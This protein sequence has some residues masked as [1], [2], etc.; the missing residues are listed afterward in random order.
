MT[1]ALVHPSSEMTPRERVLTEELE[2]YRSWTAKVSQACDRIAAGDLE[3]RILG[4]DDDGEI[5]RMVHGLNHFLDITDAFVREAKA[6][7]DYASRGKFFRRVILRGLPGTFRDAALLINAATQKMNKQAD[8]L[9]AAR[10]QRLEVASTFEQ[11][12]DGV[13]AVVAS[14]ATELQATAARLVETSI[15]TTEQSANVASAAQEMSASVQS[16]A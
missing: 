8:A 15:A 4:C 14:S 7:L 9:E 3:V 11:T 5:G 12:I 2:R 1:L 10:V 16:V 6:T 13:V